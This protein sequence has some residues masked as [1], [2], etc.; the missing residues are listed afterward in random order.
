M[1]PKKDRT[2]P[3]APPPGKRRLCGGCLVANDVADW[4]ERQQLQVA[5]EDGMA[6]CSHPD[7]LTRIARADL[8]LSYTFIELYKQC[9]KKPPRNGAC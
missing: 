5:K 1:P 8:P 6:D 2:S 4:W 7:L 3:T 9:K